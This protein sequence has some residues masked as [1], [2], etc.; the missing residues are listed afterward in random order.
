M[1][2]TFTEMSKTAEEQ[3]FFFEGGNMSLILDMPS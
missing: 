2:V 3:V 1:E